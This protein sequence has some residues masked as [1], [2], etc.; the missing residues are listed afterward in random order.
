MAD[1]VSLFE[2]AGRLHSD[3]AVVDLALSRGNELE[4]VRR[5]GG[6]LPDTYRQGC[7]EDCQE[8]H[9]AHYVDTPRGPGCY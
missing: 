9:V 3:L 5:L 1:E 6:R 7:L 2:S 4:F 8:T